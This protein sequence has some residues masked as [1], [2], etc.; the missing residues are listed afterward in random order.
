MKTLRIKCPSCGVV[1]EVRN[2]KDEAVKRI[3]CPNCKKQLAVT[4]ADAPK[5]KSSV[6]IG[7]LYE[8]EIRY[9]LQEGANPLPHIASDV[10]EVKVVCLVSESK[11]ILRVLSNKQQVAVNGQTLLQDDEV[12]LLRGDEVEINGL[13]FSFDKPGK[14]Q[15]RPTPVPEPEEEIIE[16]PKRAPKKKS[17][18]PWILL[19]LVIA[20]VTGGAIWYFASN[21]TPKQIV[22]KPTDSIAV[23]H[24]TLQP[25]KAFEPQ[26]SVKP[27]KEKE[28][29]RQL[30]PKQTETASDDYSLEMRAAKGNI[31]AQ[32]QLGMRW[33]TSNDCSEVVKGVKYLESAARNGNANAQYALGII[34]H[35]GSPACGINR[36]PALSRQYMQMAAHKGL[37]KARRFLENNEE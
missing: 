1:L 33:V 35:K 13:I 31:Q 12:V 4:F 32:Y 18:M 3:T 27:K 29:R 14:P 16:K 20:L 9:Q 15:D 36:N 19:S 17:S 30:E 5:P 23:A 21:H 24:D 25:K 7:A 34:Y 6:S 8:G 10:A 37:E 22:T 28:E 2:S 11:H 26:P